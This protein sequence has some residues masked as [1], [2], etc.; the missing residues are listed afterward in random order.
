MNA[1]KS[2]MIALLLTLSFVASS[3]LAVLMRLN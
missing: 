3:A 1:I 2:A